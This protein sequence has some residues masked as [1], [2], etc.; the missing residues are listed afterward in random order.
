MA[1]LLLCERQGTALPLGHEIDPSAGRF[2]LETGDAEGRARVETQTAV[3]AGGEVVVAQK[4]EGFGA[5]ITNLPGLRMAFGSKAL[6]SRRMISMVGGSVPQAPRA[7][8]SSGE[9]DISTREPSAASAAAR[10]SRT[11]E[12]FVNDQCAMPVPGEAHQLEL[13]GS[14]DRIPCSAG[15]G[16]PIRAQESGPR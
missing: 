5:Q 13:A 6:L 15:R 11:S 10:M 14:L 9:A 12:A 7:L 8:A 4:L 1:H 2:G 3:N 16:T